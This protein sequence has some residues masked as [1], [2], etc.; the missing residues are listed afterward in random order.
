MENVKFIFEKT[1]VCLFSS[2][3]DEG[4]KFYQNFATHLPN[5]MVSQSRRP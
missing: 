3:K 1:A 4:S 2:E 5:Y